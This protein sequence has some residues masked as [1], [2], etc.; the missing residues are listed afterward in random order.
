MIKSLTATTREIDDAEAAVDEIISALAPET[1][2]LKNSIGIITCFSEFDETGVLKAVCDALPFDCIGSTSNL[3]SAENETDQVILAITVLTSDD[4]KFESILLPI[5]EEN[6]KTIVT[7]LT[8]SLNQK[9]EKPALILSFFPLMNTVSGDMILD[10][11]DEATGGIPLFGTVAI[12]HTPGYSTACTIFN[13]KAYR[14]AAVTG[15]IYGK[16]EFSFEIASLD[17]EKIGKQKAI[18]TESSGNILIGVNGKSVIDYLDEIGISKNELQSRLGILPFVVDHKDGRKPVARAVFALTPDGHTVCGGEMPV[19]ATLAV[20]R[21]AMNDV[22][23]TTQTAI[24]QFDTKNGVLL[25]YSC[26]ARYLVLGADS[27]AEAL[28]VNELTGGTGYMY[29]VSGGEICPLPDADGKLK[30]F[31]HN[32]TNVFCKLS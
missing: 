3:C 22:L 28:R 31:F 32:Y 7:D 25:S 18:I 16:A 24:K 29:S 17:E 15:L 1:N 23:D 30:N 21:I 20:G 14:E 27:E 26:M 19:G 10:A 13:G 4:C 5:T 11:I 8:R 9:D 12:D 6:Q 2:L